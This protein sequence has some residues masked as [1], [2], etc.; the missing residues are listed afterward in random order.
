MQIRYL[1]TPQSNELGCKVVA[2]VL[3]GASPHSLMSASANYG[4]VVSESRDE[5]EILDLVRN[6]VN[7]DNREP[8]GL[9][10]VL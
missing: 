1:A 10:K 7:V 8:L 2:A 3:A 4:L 9:G 5:L 6:T